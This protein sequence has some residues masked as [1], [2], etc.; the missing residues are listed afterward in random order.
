MAWAQ[1][2]P[3]TASAYNVANYLFLGVVKSGL[4]V[5]RLLVRKQKIEGAEVRQSTSA[6]L[7][8][9]AFPTEPRVLLVVEA[10][11][12]QCFQYRV[13]QKLDMLR[14]LGWRSEWLVWSD[15]PAVERALHFHDV[16][17]LYRVPGFPPV[18]S[19]IEQALALNKLLIY[20]LDDLVFDRQQI[21]LKFN[22]DRG[23]LTNKQYK[24]L[25]TGADLYKKALSATPF[26][27]VSTEPLRT[28]VEKI[29]GI[30]AFVL[31]N[32]V[33]NELL[34]VMQD[35]K[36]EQSGDKISLFY[37]SGTNTHDADFSYVT[38]AVC[39]LL[40]DYP[41]LHLVVVGP[42]RLDRRL[43]DFAQRVQTIEF[44][45]YKAYLELL[46]YADINI[47]PL[48]PGVFAD[49]KSEIKWMEA[50]ILGVPSVVTT[51]KAYAEVIEQ[52][53]NGFMADRPEQ[54][55]E[56]LQ[57]LIDEP[58]LR[59]RIGAAARQFIMQRYG[60]KVLTRRFGELI[61]KCARQRFADQEQVAA[62]GTRLLIV[63]TKFPPRA[64]GGATR[65]AKDLIDGLR[66]NHAQTYDIS[67]FTC[68]WEGTEPYALEKYVHDGIVVTAISIPLRPDVD[69]QYRDDMVGEIF[70]RFLNYHRPDLI[71]FH[72]IQRL[73]AS[74]LEAAECLGI[75][76]VVSVHDSWWI[77][78]HPFMMD[79]GGAL[80]DPNIAN[81]IVACKTSFDI[82]AT[83]ARN[84]YLRERLNRADAVIAVSEYQADL[85]HQ[86]GFPQ[87]QTIENGVDKINNY[88][89]NTGKSLVLGYV[90][91]KA[92]HKGYYFL[93][94]AITNSQLANIE[95]IMTDVFSDSARIRHQKWGD[96]DVRIYP[97][98]DFDK[99]G[100]FY[101]M[102]DVL[103]IP[104]L[105]PESFGLSLREASLLGM[106]VVAASIGGMKDV[107]LDGRNGFAFAPGDGVRFKEILHEL[108]QN[109]V[110]YKQSVDPVVVNGL[111]INSVAR[112]VEQTHALYQSLVKK[113]VVG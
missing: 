5:N 104:S 84:R 39:E 2:H 66:R 38:T 51:T 112:N 109:P 43:E 31:P 74:M 77:S 23:Q 76:H 42:V 87:T 46:A 65:V 14:R 34:S 40:A 33:S 35:S 4:M 75:P 110:K 17:V 48:E 13:Q 93:K 113:E 100:E 88:R 98:Y 96:T 91:G 20:D 49:C 36:A 29:S 86:N 30:T 111:R 101:S 97:K 27:F 26:C 24:N 53:H 72:S 73:T 62:T 94:D 78:D 45:D 16:V 9:E 11:I 102:I 41:Q 3:L 95:L 80:V 57:Q 69:T 58:G 60:A 92:V 83:L 47:A 1:R 107:I 63:N 105:W 79:D 54:W 44:L 7:P 71:H 52:G 25:L 90:G 106:W 70:N 6:K 82:N 22:D 67:V 103:I 99:A 8:V 28:E 108:D 19:Y 85:Y 61:H 89:K 50:G 81:P 64:M 15:V 32:G 68:D 10:S 56:I 59:K 55:K 37:G 18:M 12:P 21:K